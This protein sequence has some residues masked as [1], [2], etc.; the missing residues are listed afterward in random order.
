MNAKSFFVPLLVSAAILISN[1]I[2]PGHTPPPHIEQSMD[3]SYMF[4]PESPAAS[5]SVSA[6]T[7]ST[8][9]LLNIYS[10]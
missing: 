3:V 1:A 5:G 6:S 8:A 7:A 10:D 4:P 9:H 2:I